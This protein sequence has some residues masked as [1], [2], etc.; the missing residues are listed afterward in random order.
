MSAKKVNQTSVACLIHNRLLLNWYF[1]K[2]QLVW[3]D[4]HMHFYL[5]KNMKVIKLWPNLK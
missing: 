3:D 5:F 1:T 4:I 2:S